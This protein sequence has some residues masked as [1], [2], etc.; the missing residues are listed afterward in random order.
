MTNKIV[1]KVL[2]NMLH[3]Y[4]M[5]KDKNSKN[6]EKGINAIVDANGNLYSENTGKLLVK[7]K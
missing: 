1:E 6:K 4:V 2:E 5:K 7:G 3:Q